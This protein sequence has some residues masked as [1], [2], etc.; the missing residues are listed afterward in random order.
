MAGEAGEGL[1][2]S[3]VQR[4][5]DE[6]ER[7]DDPALGKVLALLWRFAAEAARAEA[8]GFAGEAIASAAA[9]Q[10]RLFSRQ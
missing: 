9:L 2:L 7:R 3:L 10:P 4:V 8:A 1:K 6:C 5:I